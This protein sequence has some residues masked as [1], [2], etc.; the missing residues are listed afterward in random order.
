MDI[1][2]IPEIDSLIAGN[3][4]VGRGI[5]LGKTPDGKKAVSAYFIMGRSANSRN[6]V[7]TEKNGEV[8]TEP[9]DASKVEDPSLIIYAALRQYENKLIV[10]NGNQ[11]DTI[12]DG[13]AGGKTFSAALTSREFE[14]DAPNL[15]PRISGMITFENGD[16]TYEMSILKSADAAGTACNRYTFSY[17]ALPGLGHFIHTYVCDGNPI[18]TFQGEPERVATQNDINVFTAKLWNALDENN[19]ISLYVRYTDLAT[20]SVENRLINKNV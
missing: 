16:M 7:F 20:G 18:P 14:P 11:T 15:T 13:I 4:Y 5:V 2:A 1:Y 6:R 17:A 9:F 8:F 12:Y 10:T 19:K 3:S